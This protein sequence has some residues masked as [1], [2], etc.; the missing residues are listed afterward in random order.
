M[1]LAVAR[2]PGQAANEIV[3]GMSAALSGPSAELGRGIRTGVELLLKR[4]NESG[5]VGGRRL[6]LVALD[7]SY[8]ADP[9]SGNML[10]LID[11]DNV[12]AV[13]GTA[14][15]TGAVPIANEH[16]GVEINKV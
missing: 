10:R 13:V 6:R 11:R 2:V 9:V 3:L 5:G 12:L 1:V 16:K 8:Q 7:D 4:V 14:G 15:A